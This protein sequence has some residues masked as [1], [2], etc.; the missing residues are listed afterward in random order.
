M[1]AHTSNRWTT[2]SFKSMSR[3]STAARCGWRTGS[4]TWATLKAAGPDTTKEDCGTSIPLQ[5]TCMVQLAEGIDWQDMW[6]K[7]FLKNPAVLEQSNKQTRNVKKI[8]CWNCKI[9]HGIAHLIWSIGKCTQAGS[10]WFLQLSS[11]R[12]KL[13]NKKNRPDDLIPSAWHFW[14]SAHYI[15]AAT[16]NTALALWWSEPGALHLCLRHRLPQPNLEDCTGMVEGDGSLLQPPPQPVQEGAGLCQHDV[17]HILLREGTACCM[18]LTLGW[19]GH[20]CAN[21]SPAAWWQPATATALVPL[22]TLFATASWAF[23]CLFSF[24][25]N[26]FP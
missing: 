15:K 25:N 10:Q 17:S 16:Q 20:P 5:S 6:I 22:P 19:P 3:I 24:Q 21:I 12:R 11:L 1:K 14:S 18:P 4:Q 23:L 7:K 26:A 8:W 9:Y 2:I 13:L